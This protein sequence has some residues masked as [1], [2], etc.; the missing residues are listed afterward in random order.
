MLCLA[1]LVGSGRT[2]LA[3]LI[4]GADPKSQGTVAIDGR[5]V[6]IRRAQ[7]AIAAG[8]VYLTED[9]RRLGLFLDMSINDNIN[10]NVAAG[11]ARYGGFP[12]PSR[13]ESGPAGR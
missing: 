11:D 2:E 12:M 7:D 9:R 4:Y 6:D 5:H 1:G 8:I 10:I 13:R 3:R